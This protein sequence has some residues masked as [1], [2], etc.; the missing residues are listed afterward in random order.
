MSCPPKILCS[1][2]SDN[3]CLQ[4]RYVGCVNLTC[5]NSIR[6]CWDY[7]LPNISLNYT[8]MDGCRCPCQLPDLTGFVIFNAVM[9]LAVVLPVIAVNTAILVALAL[10][11]SIM[12][13][14]RLVLASILISCL[15][16]ALGLA[17]FYVAGIVLS[18]SVSPVIND[19]IVDH[20]I[21][22]DPN[23]TACTLT[24]FL[25]LFGGT[26]RLV[27][28]TIFSIVIYNTVKYGNATKK[29]LVVAVLVAVVVLWRI[30]F[31]G[32][33]PLFSQRV[34]R[35]QYWGSV[36]CF[37]QPTAD[38]SMYIFLGLYLALF[39]VAAPSVAVLFLLIICCNKCG[40][41]SATPVERTMVKFGFFLLIGNGLSMIGL[42]V[43]AIVAS[44]GNISVPDANAH[45]ERLHTLMYTAFIFLNAGL[46]PTPIMILIF[47]N[48]IWK[49]LLH[50][51]CCCMAKKRKAKCNHNNNNNNNNNNSNVEGCMV[52]T[53]V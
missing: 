21:P 23:S 12:K 35:A 47:F 44:T 40:F 49:R 39:G 20:D 28:M 48:S 36:Y 3:Q 52:T 43:P 34:V 30:T 42:L 17:M 46:I 31:I 51:L 6:Q 15:L 1:Y 10:E 45:P 19:I 11:S 24:L 25:V 16:S 22:P 14:I 18:P 38:N 2:Y 9:L 33:S 8:C 7:S 5:L 41:T 29:R 4:Y 53:G 13:V 50:W 37:V 27:F 32:T 26:A